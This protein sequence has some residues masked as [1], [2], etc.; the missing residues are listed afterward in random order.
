MGRE[1]WVMGHQHSMG[2]IGHGSRCNNA[3]YETISS[4]S[5]TD[6]YIWKDIFASTHW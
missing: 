2:Q 5:L 3:A 4:C 1:S 6:K